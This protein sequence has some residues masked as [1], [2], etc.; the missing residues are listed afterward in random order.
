MNKPIAVRILSTKD[1]SAP[2]QLELY[3]PEHADEDDESRYLVKGT[4]SC[5]YKIVRGDVVVAEDAAN[6][7]DAMEAIVNALAQLRGRF[8][9]SDIRA[10]YHEED[11]DG[12]GL[13][14]YLWSGFGADF[15]RR[16][17]EL[18][19]KEVEARARELEAA[20]SRSHR[21]DD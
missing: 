15:D 19:D 17:Q 7:S 13:P 4:W 12:T 21:D 9:M 11:G 20:H 14:A 16:L 10:H 5:A 3:H 18:V 1:G 8:R 6:G 2:V